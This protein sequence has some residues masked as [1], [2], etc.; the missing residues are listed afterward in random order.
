MGSE[1]RSQI[2]SFVMHEKKNIIYKIKKKGTYYA[3]T[4][5]ITRGNGSFITYLTLILF[6][7]HEFCS[8]DVIFIEKKFFF[9]EAQVHSATH[10]SHT[11]T[12][13]HTLLL[14]LKYNKHWMKQAAATTATLL[15]GKKKRQKT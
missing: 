2:T 8:N 9:L 11:H 14:Y 1:Q 3:L 6:L 15:R 10:H 5:N 4:N 7:T 13:A 12:I